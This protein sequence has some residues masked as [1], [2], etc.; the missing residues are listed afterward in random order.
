MK[1]WRGSR[2]EAFEP[3][4]TRM[5]CCMLVLQTSCLWLQTH[6]EKIIVH[7]C[8]RFQHVHLSGLLL[9]DW[10]LSLAELWPGSG[11]FH[12]HMLQLTDTAYLS[13]SVTEHPPTTRLVP[14][15]PQ[16]GCDHKL[17]QIVHTEPWTGFCFLRSWTLVHSG[18][19]S[20]VRHG[21]TF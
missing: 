11:M 5:N 13:V 21:E 6:K 9:H 19:G 17:T 3:R 10:V 20:R 15:W 12:K 16:T 18:L 2:S 7:T 1:S 14:P 4:R 8:F